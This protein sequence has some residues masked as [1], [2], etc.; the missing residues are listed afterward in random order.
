MDKDENLARLLDEAETFDG[1][2]RTQML[3][4]I[5]R[6]V[7]AVKALLETPTPERQQ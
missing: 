7:D 2:D 6:L 1:E 3:D 5:P 4:L